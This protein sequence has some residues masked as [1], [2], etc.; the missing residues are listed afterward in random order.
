MMPG[1]LQYH[2]FDAGP[3]VGAVDGDRSICN[4][5]YELDEPLHRF[6]FY[7]VFYGCADINEIC[8]GFGLIFCQLLDVF[9]V[10]VCDSFCN[11]WN[12]S[13]DLFTN[14]NQFSIPP[15]LNE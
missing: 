6:N 11:G 1:L 4:R 5:L 3:C 15:Y 8:T 10:S 9:F 14:N 7:I 13:V 2:A 12:R